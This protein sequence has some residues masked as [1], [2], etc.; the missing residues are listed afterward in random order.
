MVLIQQK[1]ALRYVSAYGTVFTKTV[2]VLVCIAL[3]ELVMDKHKKVC[4][5]TYRISPG[6][7]KTSRAGVMTG[8][9][10]SVNR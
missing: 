1:S 8:G 2:Y 7:G 4:N 9:S 5:T 10:H 6:T 3:I